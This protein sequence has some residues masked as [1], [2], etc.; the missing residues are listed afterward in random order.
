MSVSRR[1]I[2][3][4]KRTARKTVQTYAYI[5]IYVYTNINNYIISEHTHESPKTGKIDSKNKVSLPQ[6][7]VASHAKV[8]YF[9][10]NQA[11]SM[12]SKR[13]IVML[14]KLY[15]PDCHDS[16]R[17]FINASFPLIR[18]NSWTANKEFFRSSPSD[19]GSDSFGETSDDE[20]RKKSRLSA[21]GLAKFSSLS[22]KS[23]GD[24]N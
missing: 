3:I 20:S 1:C 7:P 17:N 14:P 19:S 15:K 5:C 18:N 21:F 4:Q 16:R 23:F 9:V 2:A 10:V 11:S 8:K 13:T 6:I 24:V 22:V 12:K